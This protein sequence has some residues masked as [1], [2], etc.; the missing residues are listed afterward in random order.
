[1]SIKLFLE[2]SFNVI[3]GLG[4]GSL[5]AWSLRN[6]IN[7]NGFGF[8]INHAFTFYVACLM[9]LVGLILHEMFDDDINRR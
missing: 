7:Y 4:F 6:E 5:F 9:M 2:F 3:G 8:P 1:M